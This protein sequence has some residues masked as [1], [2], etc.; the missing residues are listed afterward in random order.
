MEPARIDLTIYQGATFRKSLVW[1]SD[2]EVVDLTGY[3]AQ[4]QIRE[5]I[6]ATTSLLDLTTEND[7][8]VI[9]E[10]EG[11]VE[12]VISAADTAQLSFSS[13]V[14]NDDDLSFSVVA[15]GHYLISLD[16][17]VSANNTTGDLAF[18][19][20]VSTGT[21]KGR[22]TCVNLS[23]SAAA[24]TLLMSANDAA[25]TNEAVCGAS[26][27][28]IDEPQTARVLFACTVSSNATM[29]FK[30]GNGGVGTGRTSRVW[31][32]SILRYKRLD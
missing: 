15:G 3:T 14:V 32:G 19:L 20:V 30:F 10:E 9:T 7:R 5:T 12:L 21:M 13:G 2:G 31:K 11:K 26:A 17:V 29:N 18:S 6:D 23:A 4:M 28:D 27:A 24:Q 16:L 8:I 1:K 22:G 25:S